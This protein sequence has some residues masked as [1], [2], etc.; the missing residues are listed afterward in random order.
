MCWAAL[1]QGMRWQVQLGQGM[2]AARTPTHNVH[3]T[4][5]HGRGTGSRVSESAAA[6]LPKDPALQEGEAGMRAV[7]SSQAPR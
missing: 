7:E 4:G 5:S 1:C 2:Q 6:V 3:V